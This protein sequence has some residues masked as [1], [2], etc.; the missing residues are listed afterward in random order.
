MKKEIILSFFILFVAFSFFMFNYF[1]PINLEPVTSAIF[2]VIDFTRAKKLQQENE[3]LKEE[4]IK[5]NTNKAKT[6]LLEK[7]NKELKTLLNIKSSK[8]TEKT[9]ATVIGQSFSQEYHITI[10]KGSS[11]GIKKGDVA[12]F[13]TALVG[14]VTS[15]SDDIS[16]ITPI[17]APEICV[18]AEVSRTAAL[19]YTEG[20][21]EN[22]F[23]NKVTLFLFGA[24][25]YASSGDRILSS[26]LGTAYPE[27]LLL[28]TVTE[29]T[30]R[31]D[32][33]A[34]VKLSLDLFSLRHICILSEVK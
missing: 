1:N 34:E 19:G 32:R 22:F 3:A 31:K 24:G 33:R 26:G 30:D 9:Y 14:R 25:D 11:H 27:G 5:I 20:S 18:G 13:G 12:V 17:S 7:E 29:S 10:D 21:R 23:K 6:E 16:K 15:V 8:N 28:G 4:I 2:N